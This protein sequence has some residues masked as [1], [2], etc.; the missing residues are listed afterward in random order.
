MVDFYINDSQLGIS[1]HGFGGFL[2]IVILLLEIFFLFITKSFFIHKM[3]IWFRLRKQIKKMIPGWWNINKISFLT[4]KRRS[5]GFEVYIE[6]VNNINKK[7]CND[8]VITNRFGKISR[9][10]ELIKTIEKYDKGEE[11]KIKQWQR[12]KLLENIGI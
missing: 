2:L 4:I 6:L 10:I 8:Y 1:L 12:N 9:P 5:S 7:C 3:I 11:L